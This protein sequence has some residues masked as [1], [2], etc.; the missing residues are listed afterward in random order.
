MLD[1]KVWMALFLTR[2]TECFGDRIEFVGLQGSYGRGEATPAS[3]IDV[4]VIF[5]ELDPEDIEAYN[6]LLDRLP[7][8][9][10]V[11]GFL[12]GKRE[13]LNWEPSDLFQFYYDTKPVQGSLDG[14]LPRLNTE[15]VTRAVRIGACNLYHACVHNML[16]EKSDEV[17]R[18]LYKSAA[19]TVQALYFQQTGQYV[20]SHR[21]LAGLVQGPE[22]EILG[23]ALA[24]KEGERVDF[25][26]M[27]ERLFRWTKGLLSGR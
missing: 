2:L 14:L 4:V 11:C 12:S 9:E 8:R 6:D 25:S 20:A 3:D 10:M 18:G 13:L 23:T 5:D 27:S 1:I 22:A 24:L 16:H 15:A 17:L 21:E 7:H 19:F 26:G